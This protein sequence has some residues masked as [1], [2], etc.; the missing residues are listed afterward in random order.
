VL[1]YGFDHEPG[2]YRRASLD[3]PRVGRYIP[4]HAASAAR[5]AL[6]VVEQIAE[7]LLTGKQPCGILPVRSNMLS[8]RAKSESFAP[9]VL[10]G[11]ANC[12]L[13]FIREGKKE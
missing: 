10:N 1:S 3:A 7:H 12:S 9:A 4:V 6:Q 5:D 13:S 11:A 2:K 8:G